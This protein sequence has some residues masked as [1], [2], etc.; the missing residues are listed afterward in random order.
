LVFTK[1]AKL[2]DG[3]TKPIKV[4]LLA[5][6]NAFK[7]PVYLLTSKESASATE[8][9]I[10]ASLSLENVTRLGGTSEGVFSDIFDR[11][12]PN[13]WE[14][15]LSNEVYLDTKGNNYEGK[16]ISPDVDLNH[17]TEKQEFLSTIMNNLS[18]NGDAT[19]EKLINN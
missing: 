8:I 10:L 12:L 5:T 17:S 3:Y 16:G 19:I 4:E 13:G 18:S 2:G 14:F 6:D 7:K 9:M 1:K 15:G 11:L